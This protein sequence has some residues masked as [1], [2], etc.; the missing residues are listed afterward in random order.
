MTIKNGVL[1]TIFLK[2]NKKNIGKK[3]NKIFFKKFKKDLLLFIFKVY[4]EK[5]ANFIVRETYFFLS[6]K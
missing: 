1:Y 2:N 5:I 6:Q 3:N 4:E